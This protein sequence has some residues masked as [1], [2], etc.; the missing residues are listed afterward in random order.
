M[1]QGIHIP[2]ALS[3]SN[4]FWCHERL[5]GTKP[6]DK[7]IFTLSII[8]MSDI[9]KIDLNLLV[10]F[11]ALFDVRS[12]SGAAE[13][14]ALTQSTVSG[15]LKQ[16]R[17]AFGDPL[18]IR[19]QH[20][21]LPTPRAEL[22]ADRVKAL[23]AEAA[24]LVTPPTFEPSTA[25]LTFSIMANDYMQQVLMI[26]L[27]NAL[28]RQAPRVRIAVLP[29]STGRPSAVLARGEVDLAIT[30]SDYADPDIP[31]RLLYR[32]SYVGIVRKKHPMRRRRPSL[33]EFCDYDHVIASPAGGYFESPTDQALRELGFTRNVVV[34]VPS[35]HV[36][37]DTVRIID[38]V[39]LVPKRLL[40]GG[41]QE[42]RAFVPPLNVPGFDVI[43]C[44]HARFNRHPA[45]QWLRELLAAVAKPVAATRRERAS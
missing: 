14:L 21:I 27:L 4:L 44:W 25:E 33:K 11:D 17:Q 37:L 3:S 10:A 30:T 43:A 15:K 42:F 36:L 8:E 28:H 26:P 35:F 6:I 9:R 45:H 20:G 40:R 38:L 41:H 29:R 7:S 16:L 12:V 32:E 5:G 24:V 13:R 31:S 23:L 22:V 34:S 39:A 18:F 2:V 19:T 1:R